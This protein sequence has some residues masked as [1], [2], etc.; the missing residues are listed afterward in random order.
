MERDEHNWSFTMDADGHLT[1]Y[2]RRAIVWE[3]SYEAF[4]ADGDVRPP[5]A[6]AN[7]IHARYETIETSDDDGCPE[8]A[9]SFGPHYHGRCDH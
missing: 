5:L 6:I 3:G 2:H 9:R 7:K 4:V 1:I 8:C